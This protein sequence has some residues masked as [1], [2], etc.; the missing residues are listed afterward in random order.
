MQFDFF[1]KKG[2]KFVQIIKS[3]PIDWCQ[4]NSGKFALISFQKAIIKAARSTVPELFHP[5]P[6]EGKHTLFNI[7]PKHDVIEMFPPGDFK[8]YAMIIDK[9]KNKVLSITASYKLAD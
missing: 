2:N 8:V 5:C 3:P 9:S 7:S 6:Y 4:L 1:Y